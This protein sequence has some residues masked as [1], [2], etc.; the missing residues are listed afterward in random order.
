MTCV[1]AQLLRARLLRVGGIALIGAL[2]LGSG[3]GLGP[4]ARPPATVR[5]AAPDLTMVTSATYDVRPDEGRV[6]VSV[7]ITAA[8]HLKDTATR[9]YFFDFGYLTILP[10]ATNIRLAADAGG[11]PAV[12]VVSRSATG[13][14]LRLSFGTRLAA[15]KSAN[16]TLTFD[17]ADPGGAPDRL[18]RVSPSIVTFQAW[19]FATDSTP[20]SAVTI[21]IPVGYTVTIGQGP[22]DGPVADPASA[23]QVFTTGALSAP[24]GFVADIAADRPG[25]YAST[26]RTVRV[27]QSTATVELR[28]W[29]DDAAWRD[30]VADLLV[31]GLPALG[32]RI[33]APWPFDTPIAIQETLIRTSGGYAGVFDPARGLAE[34]NYAATD[35][36]VLHEAAHAWFNGRLVG[37]RWIAEGFASYY[38][39]AAAA[40]LGIPVTSPAFEAGTPGA[41]G[42]PF[43]LNAWPASGS[44]GLAPATE[45]YGFAASLALVRELAALLGDATLRATWSAAA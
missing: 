35:G 9:R 11:S 44:P 21:H 7:R 4:A 27:G 24:L 32:E 1:R 28:S 18:L 43:P 19:A 3:L 42:T 14:L 20:G 38:A 15:G 12:K 41:P 23:S 45:T 31:R 25:D 10:G 8:N 33:G 5:A 29:P 2:T 39:E 17:M 30:R 37:D 34:V 6:A 16:L 40:A 36:V 13:T 22:L 26:T